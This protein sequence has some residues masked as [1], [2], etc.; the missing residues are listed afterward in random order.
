ML[1]Q[2]LLLLSGTILLPIASL[3]LLSSCDNKKEEPNLLI[4]FTPITFDI[5]VLD[6]EGRDRVSP[7]HPH[8]VTKLPLKVEIGK[9]TYSLTPFESKI[10]PEPPKNE[11]RAYRPLFFGFTYHAPTAGRKTWI[12]SIG[13]FDGGDN[14]T[15]SATLYWGD[16]V[17]NTL[18]FSNKVIY[19][20]PNKIPE[21]VR[22]FYL[23]GNEISGRTYHFV[24]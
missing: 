20:S 1:K 15:R 18:S 17:K 11:L 13:E 3:L 9:Q 5:E 21:I 6:S 12:L 4:D 2:I 10:L 14:G 24:K 16:G 19:K 7:E 8:S 22:N 23:D